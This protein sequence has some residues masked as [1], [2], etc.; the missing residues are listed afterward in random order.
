MTFRINFQQ[1]LDAFN[2]DG[3]I[4]SPDGNINEEGYWNF[5]QWDCDDSSLHPRARQLMDLACKFASVHPELNKKRHYVWFKNIM[6]TE[7]SAFDEL[8]I[9]DGKKDIYAIK[10]NLNRE[11]MV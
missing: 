7:N 8:H 6:R 3:T 4:L 9:S 10:S 2:K 11:A 5:N 1:Q